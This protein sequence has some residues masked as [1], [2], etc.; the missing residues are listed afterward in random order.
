MNF[1]VIVCDTVRRDH[2][3]CYGGR[4][5]TPHLDA[6]ARESVVFDHAYSA[7]F[8]TLPC[9]AEMFTGRFVFPYLDWGPLPRDHATLSEVM[10]RARYDTALITDNLPMSRPGYGYE[11]GFYSREQIRGQWYDAYQPSDGKRPWPVDSQ[12]IGDPDRVQQ[13]LANVADRQS[14]EDYFAPRTVNAACRWL[15]EYGRRSRFFLWVDIFDPHEPWDPPLHYLAEH[16]RDVPW[17]LY[18]RFGEANRYTPD[19]LEA[20]RALYRG[21][22]RMTD[23]WVGKLLARVD[24]LGLRED[25]CVLFLS[26]HG[27]F[28]GEHNLLGK[29]SKVTGDIRGWPTYAEVS[30]VPMM[31][32]IPGLAPGR[33]DALVHPGDVTTTLLELAGVKP[34]DTMLTPSLRPVLTGEADRVRDVAVSSWSLRGRR[35]TRPSV[36]RDEEWSLVFWTSGLPPELYH[37]PSA[38]GETQDVAAAHPAEVRRLHGQYVRFLQQCETPAKNYWPRRWLVSWGRSRVW[39]STGSTPTPELAGGK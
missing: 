24:E 4:V 7:S 19:E 10:S 1:L 32:R 12:K 39:G 28:L 38:P 31:W 27:I 33:R 26:D 23:R 13:Y 16:E 20:I 17:I 2:L 36:I 21:E 14:E 18:P 8:P 22:V 9:R 30:R 11:R 5:G 34:P 35:P 3:G 25:T 6:L 29:S 37:R 15:E